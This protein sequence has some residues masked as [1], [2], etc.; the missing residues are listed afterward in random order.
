MLRRGEACH[1]DSGRMWAGLKHAESAAEKDIKMA[2]Y[3]GKHC[4]CGLL[5]ASPLLLDLNHPVQRT[6]RATRSLLRKT[7]F[8]IENVGEMHRVGTQTMKHVALDCGNICN[9]W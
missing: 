7:P 9:W 2:Q 8:V 4:Y 6:H 3:L 5:F 1:Y